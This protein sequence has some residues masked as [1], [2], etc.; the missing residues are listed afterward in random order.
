MRDVLGRF[1]EDGGLIE[2]VCWCESAEILVGVL[3][4]V[5]GAGLLETVDH[6]AESGDGVAKG[7]DLVVEVGAVSLLDHVVGCLLG[8]RAVATRRGWRRGR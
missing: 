4:H 3:V 8:R 2:L 7:G 1:A 5:L 6:D